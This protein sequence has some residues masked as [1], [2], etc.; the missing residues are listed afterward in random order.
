MSDPPPSL[1][2]RLKNVNAWVT[3]LSTLLVVG[4]VLYTALEGAVGRVIGRLPITVMTKVTLSLLALCLALLTTLWFVWWRQQRWLEQGIWRD[5]R[6]NR[7]CPVCQTPLQRTVMGV[8]DA[9][10]SAY[11]CAQCK[12]Y[13]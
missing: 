6:G 13:F 12:E 9:L 11:R 4:G 5:R 8:A 2:E 3:F 10:D 7:Y 1:T